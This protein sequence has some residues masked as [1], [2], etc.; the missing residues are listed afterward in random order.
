MPD[1]QTGSAGHSRRGFI[2][3]CCFCPVCFEFWKPGDTQ[4]V[5]I[6]VPCRCGTAFL[7]SP[8]ETQVVR[9]HLLGASLLE[10]NEI[11][12]NIKTRCFPH[13][14]ILLV[15][16]KLKHSVLC[17]VQYIADSQ[18]EKITNPLRFSGG[19]GLE[20]IPRT[21]NKNHTFDSNPA[22]IPNFLCQYPDNSLS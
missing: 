16:G 8:Q 6:L 14:V 22:P 21:S 20:M 11:F 4:N 15:L 12:K 5:C 17:F 3:A 2:S 18:C 19:R 1:V 9:H 10:T 13:S 7:L